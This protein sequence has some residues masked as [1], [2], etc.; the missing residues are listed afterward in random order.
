M[1]VSE[2]SPIQPPQSHF[3]PVQVADV[4]ALKTV[5]DATG[6]FPSHLLDGMLASYLAGETPED[7][8]LTIDVPRPMA[9]A[10]CAPERLTDGTWN[11][12]LIAVHPD[13]QG[14][15]HGAALVAHVEML[16][17]N[18][19]ARILLVE[20]SG[21]PSFERIRAF[22]RTLGYAEEARIRDFYQSGEDKVIF[23]KALAQ[24]E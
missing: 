22:Y 9:V 24:E 4:A 12:Y 6:L 16:V 18:R 8:W 11:L 5:I 14:Q 13:H 19:G 23:W 10:Y 17:A 7:I 3:R 2:P 21:L 20:T 1:P 15:G